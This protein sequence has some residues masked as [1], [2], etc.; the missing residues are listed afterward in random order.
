M[1]LDEGNGLNNVVEDVKD[2]YKRAV[3]YFAAREGKIE[4]LDD[5][6]DGLDSF[7]EDKDDDIDGNV[8]V[9]ELDV[10]VDSQSDAGTLLI[11]AV[12]HRQQEAMKISLEYIANPKLKQMMAK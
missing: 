4:Y 6:L 9:L 5:S 3:L 2:A 11:W 10:D 7:I 8:D 12:S 1:Q